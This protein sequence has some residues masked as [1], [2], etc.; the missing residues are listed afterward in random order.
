MNKQDKIVQDIQNKFIVACK[1][2][3]LIGSQ[4]NKIANQLNKAQQENNILFVEVYKTELEA[5][6]V[7]YGRNCKVVGESIIQLGILTPNFMYN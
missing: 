6:M 1:N 2:N 7:E 5:C 3:L 4:M